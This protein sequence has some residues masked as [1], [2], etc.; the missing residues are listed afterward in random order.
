MSWIVQWLLASYSSSR[1][2]ATWNPSDK[3]ANIS[4]SG[5]DLIANNATA[6]WHSV[7]STIS[8]SSGKWYWEYRLTSGAWLG[9]IMLGIG[10]SWATLTNYVWFDANGWWYYW[11]ANKFNNNVSPSYGATYTTNDVIWVAL[12]LDTWTIE[13]YKNN[14][15]QW[16]AY[17]TWITWPM[18]A[19]MAT[20]N[21][22]QIT[23]NFWAT[24]L[25]YS[26]PAGFNSWLY[27]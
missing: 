23:A 20:I 26:P 1:T 17:S 7:R 19:M 2:Y 21:S 10:K 27:N 12:D 25:T 4:L 11:N 18:F 22:C 3:W 24:S 15:S 9:N 13:F 6:T 8:K 16:V 14:T 5:G